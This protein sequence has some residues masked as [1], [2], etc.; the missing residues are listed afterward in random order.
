MIL[1]TSTEKQDEF[2]PKSFINIPILE[3]EPE[4]KVP[5]WEETK[6]TFQKFQNIRKLSQFSPNSSDDKPLYGL[7]PRKINSEK[8]SLVLNK[9]LPQRNLIELGNIDSQKGSTQGGISVLKLDDLSIT[10]GDF[11][12]FLDMWSQ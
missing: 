3:D 1:T 11:Q 2:S 6:K 9:K 8:K 7:S 5:C 4:E 10:S 12:D